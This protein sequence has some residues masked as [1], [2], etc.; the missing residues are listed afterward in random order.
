MKALMKTSTIRK[1]A[2]QALNGVLVAATAAPAVADVSP[3]KPVDPKG[4]FA[5]LTGQVTQTGPSDGGFGNAFIVGA[6]GCHILTN[7]HVAFGKATDAK[8]G[9]IEMVDDV[10]VGHTVNFAFDLDAK[11]GKFKR[12]LKAKVVEFGN[13][14]PGTSRGFLGDIALLRLD[15]C[16]G[17]EYGQLEI[18]RPPTG[19]LLPTGKLMTVSSSRNSS[20]K[21][22][23]LIEDG[24]KA[25]G[26]T[27]VTGMMLTNCESV[28]GMSGSMILEE[29]T[30][31]KLR[32]VGLTTQHLVFTDGSKISKSIYSRVIA[33][34]LD[35]AFG[36]APFA[37]APLADDRKPQSEQTARAEARA[38]I[39][40]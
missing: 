33:K 40:R 20:G 17:K 21:N 6:E 14:E 10:A 26:A 3:R 23:V 22:E 39:V 2:L 11:T 13:Y 28:P 27:S 16:L 32:L 37:R 5:K 25:A 9:E 24:C 19:K 18:D 1:I 15:D 34:F 29:G 4:T 38:T 31:K 36:D 35:T 8:T 30:D 12:T 7:F